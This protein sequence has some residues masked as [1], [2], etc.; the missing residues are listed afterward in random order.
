MG[1]DDLVNQ[2]KKLYEDH[3]EKVDGVLNSEQAEQVSDQVFDSAADLAKKIAPDQ[4]D[5][6][7][8]D[9]RDQADGAVGTE[10]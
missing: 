7:V 9:L 6:A 5:A 3:K 1:I 10:K 2:G 8:D 4:F